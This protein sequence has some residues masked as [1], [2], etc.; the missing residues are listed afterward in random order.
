MF[1]YR[2]IKD[3]EIED[4][5]SELVAAKETIA[6]QSNQIDELV[7]KVDELESIISKFNKTTNAKSEN[8]EDKPV[9]KVRRKNTKKNTKKEE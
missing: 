4:L 7:Y 1:G 8:K 3:K 6:T 2:L 5:K 9:K